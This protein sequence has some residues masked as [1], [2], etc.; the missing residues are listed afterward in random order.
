MGFGVYAIGPRVR[1]G[2]VWRIFVGRG[3][4][5]ETP[6]PNPSPREERGEGLFHHK[7]FQIAEA[8]NDLITVFSFKRLPCVS[9]PS[10][11]PTP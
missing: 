11:Q 5:G 2:R 8:A 6:H 1:G 10:N 4:G 7:T 9:V 3:A